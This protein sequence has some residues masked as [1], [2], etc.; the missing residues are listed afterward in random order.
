M[1]ARLRRDPDQDRKNQARFIGLLVLLTGFG[2]E[3]S[4]GVWKTTPMRRD[5]AV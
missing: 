3:F 2:F 5:V 4:G 1:F